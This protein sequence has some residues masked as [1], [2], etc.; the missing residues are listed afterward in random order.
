M[1]TLPEL[2]PRSQLTGRH[3]TMKNSLD[4]E[5]MKLATRALQR[6]LYRS[7]KPA[8]PTPVGSQQRSHQFQRN[9]APTVSRNPPATTATALD[10]AEQRR[11]PRPKPSWRINPRGG[12]ARRMKEHLPVAQAAQAQA[13]E[14]AGIGR[15]LGG[16]ELGEGGG[17]RAYRERGDPDLQS[18]G[19]VRRGR[20]AIERGS[21][22]RR[23]RAKSGEDGELELGRAW[24]GERGFGEDGGRRGA[25][26]VGSPSSV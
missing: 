17:I 3:T 26:G 16:I 15:L 23:G 21:A 24:R 18:G 8:Q 10:A 9:P 5:Q 12:P 7:S 25:G 19:A 13:R 22:G 11:I 4:S 2:K 1:Q 20:G 14:H 6:R